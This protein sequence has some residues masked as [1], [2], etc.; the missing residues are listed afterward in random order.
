MKIQIRRTQVQ[1]SRRVKFEEITDYQKTPLSNQSYFKSVEKM[2][3]IQSMA[4]WKN[5]QIL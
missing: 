5:Q 4:R 3:F 1:I 2:S